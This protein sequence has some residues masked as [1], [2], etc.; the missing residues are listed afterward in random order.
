VCAVVRSLSVLFLERLL[1]SFSEASEHLFL[2]RLK[3]LNFCFLLILHLFFERILIVERDHF[4]W[5]RWFLLAFNWDTSGLR[6]MGWLIINHDTKFLERLNAVFL[7]WVTVIK[8]MFHLNISILIDA[9]INPLI[10]LFVV[11]NLKP[12]WEDIRVF[13]VLERGVVKFCVVIIICDICAFDDFL[14]MEVLSW[15][16][17]RTHF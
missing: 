3:S 8:D 5:K 7:V 1:E 13:Y 15:V 12:G 9:A 16:V 10:Y 17:W 11:K 4:N 14:E 2:L 6:A